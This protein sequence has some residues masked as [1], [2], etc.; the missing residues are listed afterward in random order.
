MFVIAFHRGVIGENKPPD[1]PLPLREN[2]V[3]PGDLPCGSH[4][5]VSL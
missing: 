2:S 5:R 4:D 3:D 1:V